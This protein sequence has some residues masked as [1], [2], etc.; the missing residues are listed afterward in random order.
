MQQFG[1]ESVPQTT[2]SEAEGAP[3]EVPTV[4]M[5]AARALTEEADSEDPHPAAT[6]A[7]SDAET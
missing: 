5:R 2:A 4:K 7:R 3:D 6:P 1:N